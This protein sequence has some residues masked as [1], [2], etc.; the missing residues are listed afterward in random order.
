MNVR[1]QAQ[2]RIISP[3]PFL[4]NSETETTKTAAAPERSNWISWIRMYAFDSSNDYEFMRKLCECSQ[5]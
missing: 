2:A 4:V 3:Q 5:G 1:A